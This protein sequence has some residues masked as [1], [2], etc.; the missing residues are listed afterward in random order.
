MGLWRPGL[1]KPVAHNVADSLE[2]ITRDLTRGAVQPLA[3]GLAENVVPATN[4][5]ADNT[6]L[7]AADKLAEQVPSQHFPLS[8]WVLGCVRSV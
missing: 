7:P 6:L 2:D 3:K 5:F 1:L 4:D 8:Y